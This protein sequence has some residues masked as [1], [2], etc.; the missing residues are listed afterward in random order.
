MERDKMLDG[1]LEMCKKMRNFI[2]R[3]ELTT[4]QAE[5]MLESLENYRETVKEWILE[6]KEK[7]ND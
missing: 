4:S 1:F 6:N 5:S 7:E 3:S 2:L